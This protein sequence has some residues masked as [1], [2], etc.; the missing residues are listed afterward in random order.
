MK[1]IVG[2]FLFVASIFG[3]SSCLSTN[4][5]NNSFSTTAKTKIGN[6]V[7]STDEFTETQTA[8]HK[9]I[10]IDFTGGAF[11]GGDVY[12]EPYFVYDN[13]S[14]NFF[15]K[16]QFNYFG[17]NII[18]AEKLILLGNNGKVTINVTSTPE[19]SENKLASGSVLGKARIITASEKISKE[20]YIKLSEFFSENET[21]RMGF[22]TTSNK[23]QE[24]K[25]YSKRAHTI[26]ANAYLYYKENLSEKISVPSTNLLLFQ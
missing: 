24:L 8:V 6:M 3:F 10:G 11:G 12:L 5:N 9:D 17:N 4:T 7:V 20:D 23:A 22:Y 26:F 13:T 14:I 16:I 25:E 15:L 2:F 1:K 21:I 19:I 18:T